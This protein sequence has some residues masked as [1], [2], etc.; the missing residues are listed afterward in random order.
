MIGHVVHREAHSS[1]LIP[2]AAD[3]LDRLLGDHCDTDTAVPLKSEVLHAIRCHHTEETTL[4][5]EA[6]S[7]RIADGL[8]MERGR[9]RIP[10]KHGGRGINTVSGQAIEDVQPQTGDNTAVLVEIEMNNAAGV[11]V[12]DTLL[13]AKL[14]NSWLK[15]QV[16]I[17]AV[18]TNGDN[19]PVERIELYSPRI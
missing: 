16:R 14:A 8:N 3:L 19:G 13:K 9:S 2:L 5:T 7:I 1:Y 10:Y 12:V 4:T 15:R 6:G 17:I 18:N 11:Y